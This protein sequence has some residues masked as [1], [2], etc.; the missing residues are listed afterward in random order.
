V[1]VTFAGPS[2]VTRGETSVAVRT[3]EKGNRWCARRPRSRRT[4]TR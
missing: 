3:Q 1:F 4:Q 2:G